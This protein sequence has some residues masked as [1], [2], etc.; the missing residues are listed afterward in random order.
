MQKCCQGALPIMEKAAD[1]KE[2]I[3]LIELMMSYTTDVIGKF[4]FPQK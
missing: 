4:S 3:L 1:N 2:E